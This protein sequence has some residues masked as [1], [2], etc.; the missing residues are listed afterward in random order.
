MTTNNELWQP[1]LNEF[2]QHP[3]RLKKKQKNFAIQKSESDNWTLDWSG[4]D[5]HPEPMYPIRC[6]AC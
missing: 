6:Q 4:L 1:I 5:H 3:S 2:Q